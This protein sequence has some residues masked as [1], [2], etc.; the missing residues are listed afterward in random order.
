MLSSICPFF[1]FPIERSLSGSTGVFW[2]RGTVWN[3]FLTRWAIVH[4]SLC[5]T[6][7]KPFDVHDVTDWA[8]SIRERDSTQDPG[9]RCLAGLRMK[10][11]KVVVI[12]LVTILWPCM[13][14]PGDTEMQP[15]ACGQSFD[16][17]ALLGLEMVLEPQSRSM[18]DIPGHKSVLG[19]TVKTV[20]PD[21]IAAASGLQAGDYIFSVISPHYQNVKEHFFY[22]VDTLPAYLS[23]FNGEPLSLVFIRDPSP[24][25]KEAKLIAPQ[26]ICEKRIHLLDTH[27]KWTK[28]MI[29]ALQDTKKALEKIKANEF[30]QRTRQSASSIPIRD[31]IDQPTLQSQSEVTRK[32]WMLISNQVIAQEHEERALV[33]QIL[34]LAQ[35]QVINTG[36][37]TDHILAVQAKLRQLR[38]ALVETSDAATVETEWAQ[39]ESEFSSLHPAVLDDETQRKVTGKG[40]D[41][42][43]EKVGRVRVMLAQSWK[44][45]EQIQFRIS[46]ESARQKAEAMRKQEERDER[47]RAIV[48][49]R[50]SERAAVRAAAEQRE[51]EKVAALKAEKEAKFQSLLSKYHAEDMSSSTRLSQFYQNPFAYE[52]KRIFLSGAY[53]KNIDRETAIV[54][55]APHINNYTYVVAWRTSRNI[56]TSGNPIIGCIVKVLGTSTIS[57]GVLEREI[58]QVQEIEC[59]SW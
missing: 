48:R 2:V 10:A 39:I 13:A 53:I 5:V 24:I 28:D 31:L 33:T 11:A 14:W 4:D 47:E 49:Q 23:E 44:Q 35:R 8:A 21:S 25:F 50:E 18:S 59:M 26:S 36:S 34:D 57:Q 7:R 43:Y 20:R 51:R 46:E 56:A 52:G 42:L 22:T 1:R 41:D 16:R 32:D 17:I 29:P 37:V 19:L 45:A 12:L 3:V 40:I 38:Q 6:N 9:S 27:L 54:S 58:P 55:I 30:D 15:M